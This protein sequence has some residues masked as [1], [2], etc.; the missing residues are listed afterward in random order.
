MFGRRA[1][2]R[3]GAEA[4]SFSFDNFAAAF[5]PCESHVMRADRVNVILHEQQSQN[6]QTT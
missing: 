1:K 2:R 6:S 5:D 3:A 4:G